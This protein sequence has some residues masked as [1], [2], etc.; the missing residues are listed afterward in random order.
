MQSPVSGR[1]QDQ[2]SETRAEEEPS[3]TEAAVKN[4]PNLSEEEK[5]RN[6]EGAGRKP[7]GVEDVR[8]S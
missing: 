8:R 7:M 4:D 2:A 5:K 6:V 3:T 1:N